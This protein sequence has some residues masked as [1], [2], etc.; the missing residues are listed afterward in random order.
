MKED[1][2]TFFRQSTWMLIATVGGGC[3]MFLVQAAAQ[4]MPKD[5]L[6]GD[7]QYGVFVALMNALGQMAIPA[8]GLQTIFAQQA[9]AADSEEK[10]AALAGTVR[11][12]LKVFLAFWL[13]IVAVAVVFRQ[14]LLTDYKIE[15]AAALWLTLA[16]GL[17]SMLNP[18]FGGLLQGKQDFVW[19]G[20]ATIL[21]GVG[22]FAAVAVL[23]AWMHKQAAGAMAGVLAGSLVAISIFV[24]RTSGLWRGPV[25]PFAWS[26]WLKKVV[27][28]TLG[29]ASF[30]Y[31][32]TQDMITVQRYFEKNTAEYG[33]ARI[34]G[35]ALVFL[36]APLAAVMF[37]KVVRSAALSEKTNVL[38]QALG[39]TGIIGAVA[40]LACTLMP[41]LPLRILSR[42]QFIESAWL[43]P[44]FAWCM[45][46]LA[47]ANVLINNLLARERYAAVPWLVAVAVGY[48]VTLRYMH[49]SFT[50][51]IKTL[52]A[53]GLL[54]VA[55]CVVFTVWQ[56]RASATRR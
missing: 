34:V 40:A 52:G 45:L 28:L 20:W 36:T 24:W 32:F 12:V 29:L 49:D 7:S 38:A 22:R 54:L 31:M 17:V 16:V 51:V 37:P 26:S 21:N 14:N 23:V 8:L 30:T 56:P 2:L 10:R 15:N 25:A 27:P 53:F 1:K 19:F 11:G 33:A 3:F 18:M 42:D 41:E 48:G 6:T 9:V 47:V 4:R 44:W 55:V 43:V 50:S 35:A 39:A 13:C 46:P 5:P